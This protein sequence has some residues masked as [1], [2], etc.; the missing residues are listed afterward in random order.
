MLWINTHPATTTV[1]ERLQT[2]LRTGFLMKLLEADI[3]QPQFA[4]Q[5]P[6]T[7]G[8]LEK[9]LYPITKGLKL[10]QK[11]AITNLLNLR[12]GMPVQVQPGKE[13]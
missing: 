10:N 7:V 1:I 12:H 13:K 4:L 3:V 5:T 6:V 11:V 2:V 8:E 9:N